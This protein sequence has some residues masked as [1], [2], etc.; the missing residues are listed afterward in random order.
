LSV[1]VGDFFGFSNNFS[2]RKPVVKPFV[3]SFDDRL[4]FINFDA[5]VYNSLTPN[6]SRRAR[7]AH[8]QRQQQQQIC[9]SSRDLRIFESLQKIQYSESIKS[10]AALSNEF[11][12]NF[13][14]RVILK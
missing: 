6:L 2:K 3:L 1:A 10:S 14:P 7:Q 13:M 8:P 9:F 5:A 4:I 11:S 12:V